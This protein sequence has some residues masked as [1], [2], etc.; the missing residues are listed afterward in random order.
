MTQNKKV[1]DSVEWATI[2]TCLL[3]ILL[4]VGIGWLANTYTYPDMD[5]YDAWGHRLA[6]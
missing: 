4:A 5:K 1:I 3:G 2:I 6:E